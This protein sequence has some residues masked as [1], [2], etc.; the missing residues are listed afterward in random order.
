MYLASETLVETIV[1]Y[2]HRN[3][4]KFEG[5]KESLPP[6]LV[7]KIE[8]PERLDYEFLMKEIEIQC[9]SR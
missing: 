5:L 9:R 7:E 6:D 4:D 1:S 3:K 2:L 8:L